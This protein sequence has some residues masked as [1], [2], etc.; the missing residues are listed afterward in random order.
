MAR[1]DGPSGGRRSPA[2]GGFPGP[3]GAAHF[4]RR[5]A[6]IDQAIH[7]TVDI[8]LPGFLCQALQAAT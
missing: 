1:K 8:I 7:I 3:M 5:E 6:A 2:G 4:L